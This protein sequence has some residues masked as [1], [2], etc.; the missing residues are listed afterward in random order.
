MRSKQVMTAGDA[1]RINEACRQE[2]ERNGWPVS[3]AV[4]DDGGHVLSLIRFEGAGYATPTIALRK[5]QTSAITRKPSA[6][7]ESST[8]ERLVMLALPDRMPLQGALPI[9]IDGDCVGAVGVSGVASEQDEQIARA[10]I[11]ALDLR[12]G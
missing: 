1:A 6:A 12:Q 4:V 8:S 9:L 10:G 2:A 5:A 3:V 7:A 11:A